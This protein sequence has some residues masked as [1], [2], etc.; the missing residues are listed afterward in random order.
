M[1]YSTLV[2]TIKAYV[3]NDFPTTV[4]SGLTSTQQIDTFIQLAEEKVYSTVLLP[5]LRK[6]S[7]GAMTASNQYMATPTDWLATYSFAVQNGSGVYSFLLNKEV[8]FIRESFP[9]PTATGL[10]THYAQFDDNTFLLGP[11]PD[12]N[13]TAELHYYYHPESI[14]TATNTWLGDN[15]ENALL[16]GALIEAYTFMKGEADVLQVYKIQYDEVMELLM[17]LGEGKNRMDSYRTRPVTKQ[18]RRLLQM[19]PP[20]PSA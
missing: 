10:P 18:R 8:N 5:A 14:V 4:A 3:E 13:Y 12:A 19:L 16:Y 15:F 17:E 2:E 7:T 1:N 6:N 9:D 20:G 11:T